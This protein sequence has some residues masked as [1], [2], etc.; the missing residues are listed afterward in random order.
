MVLHFTSVFL[1]LLSLCLLVFPLQ[2]RLQPLACKQMSRKKSSPKCQILAEMWARDEI[3]LV[4]AEACLSAADVERH[5]VTVKDNI[6]SPRPKKPL[7]A[8]KRGFPATS[9]IRST[10]GIR[11]FAQL[12]LFICFIHLCFV[13]KRLIYFSSRGSG[14]SVPAKS[15][16]HV[17]W[18]PLW[19][20]N[21]PTSLGRLAS[22][23]LVGGD[24]ELRG[25]GWGAAAEGRD[26][27]LELWCLAARKVCGVAGSSWDVASA[28]GWASSRDV[29]SSHVGVMGRAD[30]TEGDGKVM[31]SGTGKLYQA[32]KMTPSTLHTHAKCC[33]RKPLS[34]L[35]AW[36]DA[37]LAGAILAG[38]RVSAA[39]TA[40]PL[41]PM[42]IHQIA[43]S[44]YFYLCLA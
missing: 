38:T 26:G 44:L 8:P 4:L 17:F 32:I 23:Q 10:S 11:W 35:L 15:Q 16:S 5:W 30:R 21:L 39:A 12:Y 24:Q 2:H 43:P 19:R 40:G 33:P 29:A 42:E 18:V 1:A 41:A 9:L 6:N 25:E 22:G 37:T 20:R 27:S 31:L 13:W 36:A 7:P 28:L 14:L 34:P 3:S